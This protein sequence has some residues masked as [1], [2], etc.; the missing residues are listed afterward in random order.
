MMSDFVIENGT[1]VSY[2][3][4]EAAVEIPEDAVRIGP[5]AFRGSPVERVVFP[6]TVKEIGVRAFDG[7]ASL[8]KVSFNFGL[9]RIGAYAFSRCEALT[10][11][12]EFPITL[13][14]IGACAFYGSGA[15]FVRLPPFLDK[16]GD[17]AFGMCPEL[18]VVSVPNSYR[19]GEKPFYG[20]PCI[21]EH[22][23]AVVEYQN[24]VAVGL[25]TKERTFVRL[26][27]DTVEIG[28]HAFADSL[29]ISVV[30]P[31]S[32]KRIRQGAFAD[33]KGLK[34]VI[35]ERGEEGSGPTEIEDDAFSGCKELERVDLGTRLD[36]MGERA[37]K[38]CRSLKSIRLPSGLCGI[39]YECFSKTGLTELTLP[40]NIGYIDGKAFYDSKI[41]RIHNSSMNLVYI[42]PTAYYRDYHSRERIRI[43]GGSIG[44]VCTQRIA[45][46]IDS[47]LERILRRY[48]FGSNNP[49]RLKPFCV[50]R[51][52]KYSQ[53]IEVMEAQSLVN[54]DWMFNG[55]IAGDGV[56]RFVS[57]SADELMNVSDDWH[58]VICKSAK[59]A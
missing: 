45:K 48:P 22:E 39:P 52:G 2:L 32:V 30:I 11:I 7:C 56:R 17:K 49:E 58:F 19:L 15:S 41:E 54:G 27:K 59:T 31:P 8:K 36:H 26:M 33:C 5:E 23:A 3:G 40:E 25:K 38:G 6:S 42:D 43:D 4:K 12:G 50:L 35:M 57:F 16:L 53:E 44:L 14:E 18:K 37:F 21:Y 20:S 1:L 51:S 55:F 34:T 47:Q 13:K 24:G 46:L 9:V 29:V 10:Q 28:E